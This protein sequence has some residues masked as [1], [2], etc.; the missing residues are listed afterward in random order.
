MNLQRR[1][2]QKLI[3]LSGARQRTQDTHLN[4]NYYAMNVVH[5]LVLLLLLLLCSSTVS[6][7]FI[8]FCV[9][10]FIFGAIHRPVDRCSCAATTKGM[11][12]DDTNATIKHVIGII[13]PF[14]NV[15]FRHW[16]SAIIFNWAEMEETR[17]HIFSFGRMLVIRTQ[18]FMTILF[19]ITVL[20]C[21]DQPPP[22]HHALT[23]DEIW[24]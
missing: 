21:T 4:W 10:I 24:N 23:G 1:E 5:L 2:K 22:V 12:T 14:N 6:V 15:V 13:E 8:E 16:I 20:K 3:A 7:P 18:R 17:K 19:V 11:P 9:C